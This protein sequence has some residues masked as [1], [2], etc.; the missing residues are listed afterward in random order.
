MKKKSSG[1]GTADFSAGIGTAHSTD[2]NRLRLRMTSSA[3]ILSTAK[4]ASESPSAVDCFQ[5]PIDSSDQ[6]LPD[7]LKM[8]PV[9]FRAFLKN[10]AVH[11]IQK[12][13]ESN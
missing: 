11:M 3:K 7:H 6:T 4:P 1:A 12:L 2:L 10:S 8:V 9:K 5:L 13:V